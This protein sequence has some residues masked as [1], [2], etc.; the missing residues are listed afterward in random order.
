MWKSIAQLWQ[1]K[2][3]NRAH[4]HC[5]LVTKG[6][7]RTL[8]ICNTAFALQQLLHECASVLHCMSCFTFVI[9]VWTGHCSYFLQVS[10]FSYA[11]AYD[12][13]HVT[14]RKFLI[15]LPPPPFGLERFHH[16]VNPLSLSL[17]PTRRFRYRVTYV[18][19]YGICFLCTVK[20]SCMAEFLSHCIMRKVNAWTKKV[21]CQCSLFFVFWQLDWFRQLFSLLFISG[22]MFLWHQIVFRALPALNLWAVLP[23]FDVSYRIPLKVFLPQRRTYVQRFLL[24]MWLAHEVH[25]VTILLDLND[26]SEKRN[27]WLFISRPHLYSYTITRQAVYF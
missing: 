22:G 16:Q 6:Y 19:C 15:I 25:R 2:E 10:R 4:A 8:V 24:I 9:S 27:A 13:L 20:C 17:S 26:G 14:S 7:K 5:M 12:D 1:P 23:V 3:E 11:T 21:K 18:M